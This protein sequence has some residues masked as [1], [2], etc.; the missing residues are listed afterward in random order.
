MPKEKIQIMSERAQL[1]LP[2]CRESTVALCG[3]TWKFTPWILWEI[4]TLGYL[5]KL[6]LNGGISVETLHWKPA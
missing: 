5:G 2:K 3:K 6:F 4:L 1:W